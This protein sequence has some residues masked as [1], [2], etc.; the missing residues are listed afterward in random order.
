LA[1]LVSGGKPV[2]GARVGFASSGDNTIGTIGGRSGL[3]GGIP[4]G[5]YEVNVF[6]SSDQTGKVT[7]SASD[8]S[9]WQDGGFPTAHATLNQ[10]LPHVAVSLKPASIKADGTSTSVAT[11]K[12]TAGGAP[13]TA[14]DVVALASSDPGEAV[15]SVSYLGKGAYSATIT[16][17]HTVG[18]AT[19]TATDVSAAAPDKGSATL[20]QTAPM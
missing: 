17:S 13:V 5:S 8:D 1:K 19:I 18:K 6:A 9:V 14:G 7:I 11:V 15:G 4:A 12:L 20:T 10:V 3:A 2:T 16:S